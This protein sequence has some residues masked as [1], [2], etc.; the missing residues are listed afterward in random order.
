FCLYGFLKNQRFFEP[1]FML[2]FLELGMSYTQVGTL[3]AIRE[4]VRNIFEIPSGMLADAFG[5]R[6]TMMVSFSFYIFSFILYYFADS[7]WPLAFACFVF[8]AADAFRTG[9]HKA[10]I[11]QYLKLQ[12]W[13][14]QKVHYYGHTRS[15]SQMGSAM[16]S[17]VAAAIVF[18]SGNYA[19]VF[20]F[21]LVPYVLDLLLM[22]TY[23][24]ALEGEAVKQSKEKIVTVFKSVFLEFVY[25]F[26]NIRVLKAIV[27]MSA[28]SGYYQAVKDYLQPVIRTIVLSM[29]V[30]LA[31]D[32]HKKEAVLAG[33]IYFLLYFATSFA[34]RY[35]GRV[36]DKFNTLAKPLNLT[37]II[38]FSV[39]ILIGIFYK[40]NLT[41][42]SLILFIFIYVL[43]NLRRPMAISFVT[44][45]L[46]QN[47]LA[48]VLSAE[49]QAN[50]I[51]AAVIAV[52]FGLLAD[53]FGV[54]TSFVFISFTLLI[55]S[56]LYLVGGK[57]AK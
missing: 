3:Y 41:W 20:L 46:N 17:L 43:E 25:S 11:F 23:P 7:Y 30:L 34:A 21:S 42:L 48:S 54:E 56:P 14:K 27:N 35:S 29:P 4:V 12:G 1:F 38:G 55:F 31:L 2:Y 47:I 13:E 19:S 28:F 45:Q 44:E 40:I 16:S 33:I 53:H 24:K 8:G 50:T 39:G 10:M 18:R 22:A 37:L 9:T 15:W 5:R 51:F 26:K 36:S 52:L 6:G 57:R 49:S 32:N